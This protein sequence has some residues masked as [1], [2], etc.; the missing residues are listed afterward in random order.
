VIP[1][2]ASSIVRGSPAASVMVIEIVDIVFPFANFYSHRET[3]TRRPNGGSKKNRAAGLP[4]PVLPA[5][6]P[7]QSTSAGREAQ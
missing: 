3:L 1:T 2:V 4:R 6:W 7:Q 5:L